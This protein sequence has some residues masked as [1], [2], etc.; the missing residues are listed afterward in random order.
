MELISRLVLEMNLDLI[1]NN[2]EVRVSCTEID[3]AVKHLRRSPFL[4]ESLILSAGD[5]KS[6]ARPHLL[7]IKRMQRRPRSES[8]INQSMPL[9]APLTQSVR[10]LKPSGITAIR[11]YER[12]SIM[13]IIITK[14]PKGREIEFSAQ[15]QPQ[16]FE[17]VYQTSE[18]CGMLGC[19][20]PDVCNTQGVAVRFTPDSGYFLK[21]LGLWFMT[22]SSPGVQPEVTITLRNDRNDGINSVP[23]DNIHEEWNLKVSAENW[24]PVCEQLESGRNPYLE[25]GARYWIV[26][27]SGEAGGDD[28]VWVMAGSSAG[29]SAYN[30]GPGT[31][32]KPGSEGGVPAT[33]VWGI[34]AV[35]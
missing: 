12:R 14:A 16:D 4:E 11:N 22:N 8:R 24:I 7:I 29:F 2:T 10:R 25:K 13:R 21:K 3:S 5:Y 28:G 9:A 18:P 27:E 20:G 17:V 33:I 32:W 30:D 31:P 26:A 15:S 23:G 1:V 6:P 19:W 35:Q 34:A